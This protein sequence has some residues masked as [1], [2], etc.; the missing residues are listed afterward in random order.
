ME[1]VAAAKQLSATSYNSAGLK[2]ASAGPVPGIP[3]SAGALYVPANKAAGTTSL[4][5]A[6][7]RRARVVSLI[8][9]VAPNN[10]QAEVRTLAQRQWSLLDRAAPGF[11]LTK[12][13]RPSLATTLWAAGT[14][15]AAVQA[16][17]DGASANKFNPWGK[18]CAE[19]VATVESGGAPVLA[20]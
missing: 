18:R 1:I 19:V 14:T 10:A 17:R 12:V 3:G 7:F 5:A 6:L 15:D 2:Q 9:V 4:A 20:A 16:W 11:T 13:V 8:E